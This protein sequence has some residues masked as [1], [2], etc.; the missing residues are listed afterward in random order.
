MK[1][2]IFK[3]FAALLFAVILVALLIPT[4]SADDALFSIY[5]A[6]GKLIKTLNTLNILSDSDVQDYVSEDSPIT[7][8]Q[9][10]DI[11][12]PS[13]IGTD[14]FDDM[15]GVY[16]G[17]DMT[18]D[19]NGHSITLNGND[20]GAGYAMFTGGRNH[21]GNPAVVKNGSIIITA[22]GQDYAGIGIQ[23]YAL[24]ENVSITGGHYGVVT[25]SD[26]PM[27]EIPGTIVTVS[28]CVI[29]EYRHSSHV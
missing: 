5:D 17:P 13:T 12:L 29:K 20:F 23:C 26:T 28:N 24:I 9:E 10:K 25:G 1:K 6:D 16:I 18:L 4:A 11:V 15:F 2:K 19:M 7:I 22:E 27:Q 8:I 14:N 3:R 21:Y